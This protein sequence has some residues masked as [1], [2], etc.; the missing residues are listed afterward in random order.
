MT[1]SQQP[2]PSKKQ[3]LK[4]PFCGSIKIDIFEGE[5]RYPEIKERDGSISRKEQIEYPLEIICA[6]CKQI[7]RQEG[8]PVT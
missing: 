7:V 2:A 8:G 1:P 5:I 4:C 6:K 3:R